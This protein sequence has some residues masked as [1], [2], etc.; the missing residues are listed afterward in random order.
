[1]PDDTNN[2]GLTLVVGLGAVVVGG[3]AGQPLG[4]GAGESKAAK[5]NGWP[6]PGSVPRKCCPSTVAF[7]VL[8]VS[9][10]PA[11][12]SSKKEDWKFGGPGQVTVLSQ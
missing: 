1:L 7:C 2:V 8:L 3:D 11:C 4:G 10:W 5:E 12:C 9:N 6:V